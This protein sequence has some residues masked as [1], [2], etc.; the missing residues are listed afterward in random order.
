MVIK[1]ENY[2]ELM[3]K[4]NIDFIILYFKSVK[5]NRFNTF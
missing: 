2:Y 5:S 1:I 4:Y 3:E